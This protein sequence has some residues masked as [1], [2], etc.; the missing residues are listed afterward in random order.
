MIKISNKKYKNWNWK[1]KKKR[2]HI[3]T[4]SGKE[5]K[6]RKKENDYPRQTTHHSLSRAT[7]R[8]RERDGAS[9]DTTKGHVWPLGGV[10][11]AV[12]RVQTPL[13]C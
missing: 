10:T 3:C 12:Q 4:F 7:P 2:E 6:E 1:I 9:K 11:C 13:M 5:R 8:E